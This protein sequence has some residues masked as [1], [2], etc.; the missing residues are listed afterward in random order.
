MAMIATSTILTVP[1]LRE[2]WLPHK[3]R[4]NST[5]SGHPTA[6]RFHR[7]CSWLEEADRCSR[8]RI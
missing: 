8:V 1:E 7:A 5:G 3:E 4:L 6:V 2:R